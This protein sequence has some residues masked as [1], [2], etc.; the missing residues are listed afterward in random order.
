MKKIKIINLFTVSAILV[1][2]GFYIVEGSVWIKFLLSA[3]FVLMGA[4][5]MIYA[6]KTGINDKRFSVFMLSGL[7]FA[8]GG[9]IAIEYDFICGAALFAV[10][11]IL[12]FSAYCFNSPFRLKN[13][14][15]ALIP[16]FPVALLIL[17]APFFD[18]GGE[19][20]KWVCIAYAIIISCMFS[21]A[22]SNFIS[23]KNA[24]NLIILIGSILFIISDIVLLFNVFSEIS[25]SFRFMCIA[26]YY[27]AQ[28]LLA[29]SVFN[30]ND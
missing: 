22:L 14:V 21:K 23:K 7:L 16:F 1:G 6:L 18:F 25:K 9:D 12:F 2:N 20:M 13:L 17:F 29:Y 11:H 3:L 30:N 27:P 26:T 19:L 8:F 5:N 10:G 24:M 28:C 4:L 15:W